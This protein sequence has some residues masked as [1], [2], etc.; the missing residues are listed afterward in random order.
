M[1]LGPK[2]K[3]NFQE[4]F[5]GESQANRKYTAFARQADEE[6]Y[7]EVAELF[8]SAAKGET[9]HALRH[10]ARLGGVGSTKENLQ[11]AIDGE[12]YE[13]TKM[14]PRMAEEAREEGDEE[15]ARWFEAVARAEDTHA[16]RFKEAL[17]Q[18]S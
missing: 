13:H 4:A 3:K 18:L 12:T 2:T 15:S 17:D 6:G 11:A 16:Q 5:A 8:R 10:L 14:Y 7:P 9:A 1:G